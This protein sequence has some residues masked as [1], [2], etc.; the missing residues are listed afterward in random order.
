MRTNRIAPSA[1]L[2]LLVWLSPGG[3]VSPVPCGAATVDVQ[4]L[5]INDFHGT[6]EPPTGSSGLMDGVPAG[7]AAYLATHVAA[8]RAST[9]APTFVLSAGDN[10]GA[11]P[12]TS[13]L[14]HDEP[15]IAAMNLI[16]LDVSTVGEDEFEGGVAEL[17]RLARGGCHP[18]DGCAGGDRYRGADFDYL[19]ANVVRGER[20]R[21]LFR[22]YTVKRIAPGVR[23]AFIGVTLESAPDSV[24]SSFFAPYRVTDE[25][26][27]INT[28]VKRLRR[29]GIEAIVVLLHDGTQVGLP[30]DIDG[31]TNISGTIVDTVQRL[32]PAV[33]PVIS[34]HTH[35]AYSCMVNSIPVTS[36]SSFGR[37]VTD[38]DVQI[39][40]ATRDVVGMTI[41]N[42]IV[43]RD[44][45]PDPAMLQLVARAE[46]AAAPIANRT[47]GR[48]TADISR[49]QVTSREQALGDVVADAQLAAT[50]LTA[51]GAQIALVNPSGLRADLVFASS[52]A[53]EGDGYVSYGEAFVVQPS[54]FPLVTLTLTGSQLD[55]LLEQQFC[56]ANATTPRVLLPSVGLR[57]TYTTSQGGSTG[58]TRD[59]VSSVTLNGTPI[60][61]FGSYRVT[62]NAFLASGGDGFPV[63]R[64]GTDRMTGT[65]D[66]D[67][68]GSYLGAGAPVSPPPLNRIT[69]LP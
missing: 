26:D 62:V 17:R 57:Y 34:G 67:A 44:V 43:T 23:V 20:G 36:A 7:G 37:V 4:L 49:T 12:V 11:S 61:P 2:A 59:A 25:A 10:V 42:V 58:C 29:K 13:G 9:P 53:G 64:D 18:V 33:D 22:P 68:L 55:L 3:V 52:P 41:D 40:T 63:L 16:G 38:I 1:A 35:Q 39:D 24:P 15:A 28:Y 30:N 54:S 51:A 27:T 48:I 69:R 19:A 45:T 32:D 5:A 50:Q 47:V 65:T 56:G 66:V 6:L 31:C 14:L 8:L 21:P 60:D 46:S